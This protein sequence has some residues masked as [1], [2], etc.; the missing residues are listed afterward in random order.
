MKFSCE[1]YLLQQA[2]SITSRCAASKSP[3]P[4]LEGLLIQ[5]GNDIRI[6]GYD[7]K[8]GIYTNFPADIAG[9]GSIVL[10]AR[11]FGEIVRSLPD[12]IVTLET[13]DGFSTSITCGMSE[14]SIMGTDS[15]EYPELPSVDKQNA[16]SIPQELLGKMIRQTVFAVSDNESRPIYT[17]ALFDIEN[18]TLSIVAV[19]GYRLALRKEKA[20]ENDLENC[21]FIVPGNA[22]NDV[23]KLCADG[24]E[25]VNITVG[26]KHISFVVGQ[27]V[28]ISRRLEG[29]FLNY[30]KSVPTEFSVIV[31]ADKEEFTRSVSRV[32][33]VIDERTKSP[34]RVSVEDEKIVMSCRSALGAGE[35]TCAVKNIAGQSLSIGINNRYLLDALKAAP[36]DKIRV[37]FNSE[38]APCVI[39]AADGTDSF[40]YM[41][42][43][44]R[45]RSGV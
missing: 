25:K 17:G 34:L 32:S 14:F 8:K 20:E 6:T 18:D 36:S 43:P 44:V 29:E 2:I 23:E 41:I 33:L 28:L 3:I 30:K 16:I 27:T 7:L 37:G 4:A 45:L 11:L 15:A 10:N 22:L 31:E 21:S 40:S 19:D 39:F 42:L 9:Q 5:A 1:K 13:K 12:G 24:E 38:S 35:D 26:T